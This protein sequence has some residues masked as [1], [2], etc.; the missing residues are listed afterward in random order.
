MVTIIVSLLVASKKATKLIDSKSLKLPEHK[1]FDTCKQIQQRHTNTNS[2]TQIQTSLLSFK[3]FP[4][5][6]FT[7]LAL[8][9]NS[10][11]NCT[12][13]RISKQLKISSVHKSPVTQSATTNANPPMQ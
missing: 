9:L 11:K 5:F 13:H 1:I 2:E 10:K 8:L 3:I 4:L 6:L 12:K 7:M